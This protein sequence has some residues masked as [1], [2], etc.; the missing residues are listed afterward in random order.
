MLSFKFTPN[1]CIPKREP[2]SYPA[3]L[4]YCGLFVIDI[5]GREFF[6]DPFFPIYEFLSAMGAWSSHAI[7]LDNMTYD[8][9]ETDDNPLISFIKDTDGHY[10]ISSTWQHFECSRTFSM[11]EI[12]QAIEL[13]R[14]S[15][16]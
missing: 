15:M 11:T 3:T 12:N 1:G 2:T 6:Y 13:L 9:L 7:P 4:Q 5:D 14:Q 16:K 8:S 10:R